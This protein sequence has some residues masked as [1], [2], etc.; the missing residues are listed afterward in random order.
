[1]NFS[2]W[3]FG[4]GTTSIPLVGSVP[5]THDGDQ[6]TSPH[7]SLEQP[8]FRLPNGDTWL[9]QD[10]CQGVLILGATGSGKTSGSGDSLAGTLLRLG[11]G[12]LVLCVK[13]G[14]AD[15]WRDIVRQAG[16]EKDL[17]R[18][19]EKEHGFNVF[20]YELRRSG[21]GAGLTLNL[22]NLF[23]QLQDL[24]EAGNGRKVGP[25]FWERACG[26]CLS[27][28]IQLQA[29]RNAPFT[30]RDVREIIS[31]S[32]HSPQQAVSDEWEKNS[33]C[34]QA[35][36]EVADRLETEYDLKT[37]VDYF[38]VDVPNMGDKQRSG[39]FETWEGLADPLLRTPLRQ[40]FCEETTWTPEDAFIRGKII[41][42]DLPVKEFEFAGKMAGV[43][44]KYM[45]Q[46]AV[47]RRAPGDDCA[48]RPFFIWADEFENFATSY[49][50]LFQKTARSSKAIT[51]YI[52]QNIPGILASLG[53]QTGEPFMRALLG[54]LTTQIF[55]A[56][57]EPQTNLYAAET[58]GKD[59]RKLQTISAGESHQRLAP[60]LTGNLSANTS[61]AEHLDYLVQPVE[62]QKFRTGGARDDLIVDAIF[63][64][65]NRTFSDGSNFSRVYFTQRKR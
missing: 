26:R 61:L 25:D 58:I 50:N 62:F 48:R 51:V 24:V 53:G 27:N 7:W 47:E 3:F 59:W 41:L 49:D 46:K 45:C 12:G 37:A 28:A 57:A 19:T 6:W 15:D 43:I 36:E 32:P 63:F 44:A 39:I 23:R 31:S 55:H 8:L 38:S 65:G 22:V 60:G 56:N 4:L 17:I 18:V 1:M 30:L 13:T 40:K 29:S 9:I 34:A 2:R 14:E 20:E 21:R 64:Q 16:R 33:L 52:G 35:M 11:A 42:L 10:A 5:I 54:N